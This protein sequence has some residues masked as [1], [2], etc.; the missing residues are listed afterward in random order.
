MGT[1]IHRPLKKRAQLGIEELED[2]IAPAVVLTDGMS[3]QYN[4]AD[5][6]LVEATFFGPG[7][8]TLANLNGDDPG[9]AGEENLWYVDLAGT[10]KASQLYIR[11]VTPGD[12]SDNLI[13]HDI[14]N[15]GGSAMGVIDLS[16]SGFHQVRFAAINLTY[17]LNELNIHGAFY[18]GGVTTTSSVGDIAIQYFAELCGF[19]IGGDLGRFSTGGGT[20]Q[21]FLDVAGH[22]GSAQITG[23][24]MV[25]T[26]V[27]IG[28]GSDRFEIDGNTWDSLFG[29]AEFTFYSGV[30]LF[31][32]SGDMVGT[33]FLSTNGNV[34]K[35]DIQGTVR[36]GLTSDT[37]ISLTNG[38]CGQ[39]YIGGNLLQNGTPGRTTTLTFTDMRTGKIEI[40]GSVTGGADIIAVNSGNTGRLIIDGDLLGDAPN[41]DRA[42]I[43]AT[44]GNLGTL[45]IGGNSDYAQIDCTS[46][47]SSQ[48]AIDGTA[49]DT[50]VLLAEGATGTFRVGGDVTNSTITLQGQILGKLWLGGNLDAGSTISTL[51]STLRQTTV[52]GDVLGGSQIALWGTTG[53]SVNIGGGF[54]N[55]STFQAGVGAS[56]HILRI[57]GA[58]DQGSFITA[59]GASFG[60]VRIGGGVLDGSVVQCTS[61]RLDSL[62]IGG[63][64]DSLGGGQP[65]VALGNGSIV[66]NV[67]VA[68]HVF[69]GQ[70]ILSQISFRPGSS[71]R[72]SGDF[73]D[74]QFAALGF[75]PLSGLLFGGHVSGSTFTFAAAGRIDRISIGGN[76]SS[77]TFTG[78]GPS[79]R[80]TIGGSI[81]TT[82]W[83][84]TDPQ[85]SFRTGGFVNLFTY[86]AASPV[87]SFRTGGPATQSNFVFTSGC[88]SLRIDGAATN[89]NATWGAQMDMLSILGD[90]DTVVLTGVGGS[91]DLCKIQGNATTF[92]LTTTGQ[93]G[94]AF[95]S[96]A[97][98]AGTVNLD[99]MTG[100]FRVGGA[101]TNT[102]L[103]F[104]EHIER[105]Q[106]GS[107]SN[108]QISITNA[109]PPPGP[110]S[111]GADRIVIMGDVDTASV[112][113]VFGPC[114]FASVRG[115]VLNSTFTFHNG[116]ARFDIVG[117]MT[118][119]NITAL[120]GGTETT[121]SAITSARIGGGIWGASA[122]TIQ[123]SCSRLQ[124]GQG[125]N[126]TSTVDIFGYTSSLS[127]AGNIAAGATVTIGTTTVSGSGQTYYTGTLRHML[128]RGLIF[129]NIDV[130]GTLHTINSA[131]RAAVPNGG[132]GAP[133]T[134]GFQPTDGTGAPIAGAQVDYVTL[135]PGGY[136]S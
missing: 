40:A 127:I 65:I 120:G 82:V 64:I 49:N 114:K 134:G 22:L 37:D 104:T 41:T 23:G 1:R 101:V 47:N 63:P 97:L 119:S 36:N 79:G 11:D 78:L 107:M 91:V 135:A 83:Q 42:T 85:G 26:R 72:V 8:A 106:L 86:T 117:R 89:T 54:D 123:G 131:G 103:T 59:N 16:A 58:L 27:N 124:V 31:R 3:F 100:A 15:F 18:G 126:D 60:G 53:S 75:T 34:G 5:G 80:T 33:T 109:F 28:S 12:G 24:D 98:D 116:L 87:G 51:A 81:D 136:V 113:D 66:G 17:P 133:F 93:T 56:F 102:G 52:E 74:S 128:V 88:N 110:A 45:L 68:G 77:S 19:S 62:F 130:F 21:G 69:D 96:G 67:T 39:I 7:S 9:T 122:L 61:S 6:D 112:V 55:A 14:R 32:V 13:C 38:K 115:D 125:L 43:T 92:T 50:Q 2:R 76:V 71:I 129:G 73:T 30:G 4:A 20:M 35:L 25:S 48:V 121:P 94:R 44:N 118:D 90:V 111:G 105:V 99:G 108:S 70:F 95:I 57:G 46:G 29:A 10:T 132:S 84:V